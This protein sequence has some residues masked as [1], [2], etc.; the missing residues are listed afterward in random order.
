MI[1]KVK[2]NSVIWGIF[3][4]YSLELIVMKHGFV[5]CK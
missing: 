4:L 3:F 1:I 5:D 2:S